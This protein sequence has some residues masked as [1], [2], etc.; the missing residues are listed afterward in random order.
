MSID[1]WMDKE[2]VVPLHNGILL[3]HKKE[4]VWVSSNEVDEPRTYY[5]EWSKSE[6][7]RY[8]SY[9]NAYTKDKYHILMHIYG[10]YRKI[11][12]KNIYRV[13]VEKRT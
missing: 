2:F 9:S 12:L 11:V 13:A 6:R 3:S 10:I 1:R 5:T 7:E 4:C 8:I